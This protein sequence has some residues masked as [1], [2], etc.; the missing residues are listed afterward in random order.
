MIFCSAIGLI[1]NK[2]NSNILTY[3]VIIILTS[4]RDR[5][6]LKIFICF[7]ISLFTSFFWTC[8][9]FHTHSVYC[10]RGIWNTC[11][12]VRKRITLNQ[13]CIWCVWCTICCALRWLLNRCYVNCHLFHCVC[14][15]RFCISG[16]FIF[17]VIFIWKN[18]WHIRIVDFFFS[19]FTFATRISSD[20]FG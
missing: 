12:P 3:F 15:F 9:R 10:H 2:H 16:N 13:S 18:W 4:N 17:L 7:F 8:A 20:Y 5:A 19:H 6:R 1:Y 11:W 14:V